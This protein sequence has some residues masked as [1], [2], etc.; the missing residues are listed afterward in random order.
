MVQ[1]SASRKLYDACMHSR[2]IIKIGG[3]LEQQLSRYIR[4]Y[5]IMLSVQYAVNVCI[6][7]RLTHAQVRHAHAA[8]G[9]MASWTNHVLMNQ[10]KATK[11]TRQLF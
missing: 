11:L 7:T 4:A 10:Q 2:F 8:C 5:R 9:A 6:R 3:H 1:N